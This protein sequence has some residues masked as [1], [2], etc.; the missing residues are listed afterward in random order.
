MS[1]KWSIVILA[2]IVAVAA[3]AAGCSAPLRK[4]GLAGPGSEVAPVFALYV[5][6]PKAAPE[7][8]PVVGR[9]PSISSV[10]ADGDSVY[11]LDAGNNRVLVMARQGVA[12]SVLCEAGDCAFLLDGPSGIAYRQGR[13][14]VANPGAGNVVA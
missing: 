9:G 4:A 2:A 1:S 8:G 13:L 6:Q 10:A 11:V 5:Q 14:Y 3:V 12:T 7:G